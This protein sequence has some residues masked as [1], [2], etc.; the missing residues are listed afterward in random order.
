MVGEQGSLTVLFNARTAS[1]CSQICAAAVNKTQRI[2]T[3]YFAASSI[4]LLRTSIS[5]L[6]LSGELRVINMQS[7]YRW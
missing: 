7:L 4:H 3:E 1:L 2:G 5:A 6:V